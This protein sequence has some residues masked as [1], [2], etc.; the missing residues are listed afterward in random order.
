M[1]DQYI[2]KLL[3]KHDSAWKGHGHLAM[4]IVSLFKPEVIVDLGV[5]YGFST[6]CF[7]YEGIGKV[8]GIDWFKGDIHT[9][10]R[11]TFDYVM[12]LYQE[13]RN[14]FSIKNIE[15]IKS[16]FDEAAKSW[17][18]KIDLLHIDGLHTYEAVKN[19]Y[20]T[21][22][23]F[24]DEESIILFHDVESFRYTVGRFFNESEGYKCINFGSA[25]LGILTKSKK[26]YD[27][28]CKLLQVEINS[29][30]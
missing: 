16:D 8:Y 24:C 17:N 27:E 19:D 22:I 28:I 26:K 25:G 9:G 18:K 12:G 20:D 1:R 21:W 29:V 23:K 2:N 15:F 5:D 13:I 11:D 4:K 30:F 7:A 14:E 6:F 3:E 10:F